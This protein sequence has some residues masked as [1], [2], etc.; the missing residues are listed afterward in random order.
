MPSYN[1]KGYDLFQNK[2]EGQI[3]AQNID[4]AKKNLALKKIIYTKINRKFN[5]RLK[6]NK[7]TDEELASILKDLASYTES[8][9]TI[10]NAIKLCAIGRNK[11]NT[12]KTYLD[13][14]SARLEEGNTLFR[15]LEMDASIK[16]PEYVLQTI[17]MAE[18]GAF[19]QKAFE[20]LHTAI[21]QKLIFSAEIKK[22]L[23]YPLFIVFSSFIL[24]S[25]M[26]TVAVPVMV[27]TFAKTACE[28]PAITKVVIAISN[29]IGSYKYLLL[30]VLLIIPSATIFAVRSNP[31]IA[32]KIAK[33]QISMPFFSGFFIRSEL[34]KLLF[35]TSMLTGAGVTAPR[36]FRLSVDALGNAY[37]RDVFL[38]VSDAINEGMPISK[39][40]QKYASLDESLVQAIYLGEESS[41]LPATMFTLSQMYAEQNRRKTAMFVALLEPMLMLVVGAFVG[42]ILIAMLLPIMSISI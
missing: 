42:A 23:T 5:F 4:E 36:A 27:E 16:L 41:S 1:Y 37:L 14:L 40:I 7:L 30:A 3:E 2:I 33:I 19:L 24:L 18:E 31:Q 28:L 6:Q 21:Y 38:Q 35:V 15:S 22:A 13:R 25:V 10:T 12:I 8:A 34:S 9:I 29:F 11:N 17:K 20:N 26:F 32:K 39:A